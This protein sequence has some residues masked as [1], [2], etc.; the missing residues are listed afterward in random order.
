MNGD[1]LAHKYDLSRYSHMGEEIKQYFVACVGRENTSVGGL[2]PFALDP[3]YLHSCTCIISAASQV[4]CILV[5]TLE[6]SI[7]PCCVCTYLK[8][9]N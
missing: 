5:L 2:D 7:T 1:P 9:H 3:E 6:P 8:I 4:N